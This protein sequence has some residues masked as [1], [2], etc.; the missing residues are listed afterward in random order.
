MLPVGAY[1]PKWFMHY[2]HMNPEDAVLAY[3]DLGEPYTAAIHFQ[4]FRLGD[5]GQTD[6]EMI[7]EETLEK[8]PLKKGRFRLLQVGEAWIVPEK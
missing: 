1:E 6:P 7:V 8:L 4:T 5:E 3:K 2:A